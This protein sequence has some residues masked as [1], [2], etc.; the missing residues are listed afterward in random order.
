MTTIYAT[1]GTVIYLG[2]V[3]EHKATSVAFD[4][5]E[6]MKQYPQGTATVI[7]ERENEIY[8]ALCYNSGTKVYTSEEK[9]YGA[10]H[11]YFRD[12]EN[13][14]RIFYFDLLEDITG[15]FYYNSS[16]AENFFSASIKT[17]DNQ[18]KQI[19]LSYKL[20]SN[21]TS[22]TSEII[23][24][25]SQEV[26]VTYK[27][28]SL[29]TE[30]ASNTN[31]Y[32]IW[33]ILNTDLQTAYKGQCHLIFSDGKTVVKSEHYQT[34]VTEMT[35]TGS[36][37][38]PESTIDAYLTEIQKGVAYIE[39]GM[40]AVEN[41]EQKADEY[42]DKA[43]AWAVG[44]K[45]GTELSIPATN[46]QTEPHKENNSKF[47][48][49]TSKNH[50]TNS[51][52]SAL[53]SKSYAVGGGGRE[54]DDEDNAKYY[55]EQA[56]NHRKNA[57]SYMNNARNYMNNAHDYANF[58]QNYMTNTQNYLGETKQYTNITKNYMTNAQA[59]MNQANNSATKAFE[60]MN[61]ALKYKD[62]TNGYMINTS[63]YMN[64]TKNYMV[65]TQSYMNTTKDWKKIA[66]AWAIGEKE[67]VAVSSSD[68]QYQNNSKYW[69]EQANLNG[70]A[71]ALGTKN[72][73]PVDPTD[74]QYQ[75]YSKHWVNQ[76]KEA[77][78]FAPKIVSGM[79]HTWDTTA[80]AGAGGYIDTKIPASLS[81]S[82]VYESKAALL[83]DTKNVDAYELAI[84]NAST[85]L[86]ENSQL[87]M[88]NTISISSAATMDECWDYLS[89]LSGVQGVSIKN[90][91]HISTQGL[92]DKY[93]IEFTGQL[94][95]KSTTFDF[96]VENGNGYEGYNV[97]REEA[98]PK[99]SAYGKKDTYNLQFTD[100]TYL[101][102]EVLHG[103][104][105]ER[106]ERTKQDPS[107]LIDTYTITDTLGKEYTFEV[108]N[109][110]GIT[111]ITGPKSSKNIDTYTIHYNDKTTSNYTVT[112]GIGISSISD[113]KV[114]HTNG[115]LDTYTINFDHNLLPGKE[116]KVY[117]GLNGIDISEIRVPENPAQP[118][119]TDTYYIVRSRNG[120][121]VEEVPLKVYNGKDGLHA[122]TIRD[123]TIS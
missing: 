111:E 23:I 87:Y 65:N 60:H 41:S 8:H 28:I 84:I 44:T 115:E 42:S 69:A 104:K 90:I 61:T 97:D 34:L 96:N 48:A 37:E 35:R 101:T 122:V 43:E 89:D 49:Q 31:R 107:T 59:Y 92:V 56:F 54:D 17:G 113:T 68:E 66:E 62:L 16:S 74:P 79:W 25:D 117:N 73:V 1:L 112:N 19:P 64:N 55:N 78:Q 13:P 2:Q 103:T 50:S 72:G 14:G 71:W 7:V 24:P 46:A 26:S 77:S 85:S 47:W 91:K 36:V 53:L 105:I 116:F 106:I 80:N 45:D 5:T 10:G 4:V 95:D 94:E 121:L 29:K 57:M 67:G 22:N 18:Q 70:E 98:D 120:Q 102:F 109:G 81:I 11:Y 82:R 83:A 6:L 123:W 9:K 63:K 3:G 110:K 30:N 93:R 52:N 75:N 21:L 15:E 100:G 86:I 114:T 40:A 20:Y 38:I 51:K 39:N 12:V 99:D 118:N 27:E 33:E 119:S 58:A 32:L 76:A 88:R 108:G